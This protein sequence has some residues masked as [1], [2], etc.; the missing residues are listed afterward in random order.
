MLL[1]FCSTTQ[2]AGALCLSL[3][4]SGQLLCIGESADFG[5]CAAYKNEGGAAYQKSMIKCKNVVNLSKS[6]YC[7]FHVKSA[8]NSIKSKR[9]NLNQAR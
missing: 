5:Y 6:P 3:R 2:T 1:S 8:Y 9:M 7:D 4:S